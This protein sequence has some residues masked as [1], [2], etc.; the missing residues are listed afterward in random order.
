MKL[1]K[2][3]TQQS[4]SWILAEESPKHSA[5]FE[6]RVF[7]SFLPIFGAIRLAFHGAGI[8]PTPVVPAQTSSAITQPPAEQSK[9]VCDL[10]LAGTGHLHGDPCREE[11]RHRIGIVEVYNLK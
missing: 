7:L 5:F 8:S 10:H 3:F 1:I 2:A 6:P 4:R 9:G 11:R